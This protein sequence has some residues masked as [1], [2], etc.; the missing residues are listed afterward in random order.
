MKEQK[1]KFLFFLPFV[2]FIVTACLAQKNKS[3]TDSLEQIVSLTKNDSVKTDAFIELGK[4]LINDSLELAIK[5]LNNAKELSEKINY[6]KGLA[7]SYKQIGNVFY[8][9]GG[10]S[11]AI[12]NWSVALEIFNSINDVISVIKTEGNIGLVYFD[13]GAD[14]KALEYYFKGLKSAEELNDSTQLCVMNI[15][16][17]AV[18]FN[19]KA[20]QDKALTY[21]LKALSLSSVIKGESKNEKIGAICVNIGEVYLNRL[22]SLLNIESNRDS[23]LYY[24]NRAVEAYAGT[25]NV[26]YALNDLGKVYLKLGEYDKALKYQTEAYEIAKKYEAKNDLAISLLA[27]A[28]TYQAKGDI[29]MAL[30]NYR[31]G[32]QEAKATKAIY[33]LEQIYKGLTEVY[34]KLSDFGN[35]LKYQTLLINIK[36]EIYTFE[37]DNKIAGVE[38][39]VDIER[40][41]GQISLLAKDQELKQKEISR[42]K[43][44]RNGFMGGFAIVLLFAGVFFTQRNRI[45]KEKKRSDELLLNILPE[46]T[47]EELK[48]TGTA[49]AKSID[50]VTVMF[51]DF[52]NFTQASELLSPEQL[53]KEINI[54]YSEFDRIITKHGIEKIKTIGDAY[55]CAGGLPT[56]N[57]TNPID[58]IK[59]GLEM[60]E[61]IERNKKDR[62]AI[63]QPYFELRLGIHTGPVVAGIVGIKKF[64]YD[65]W[66]DTVNTASRMESSGQVGKVNISGSTYELVKDKF[67]CTHRGKIHAKNKGEI[68]MY[69]VEGIA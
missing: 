65:I 51:T 42:Q 39:K 14:E 35:A 4:I 28:Q 62:I 56:A 58:V 26:P 8:V 3:K 54:C 57:T 43:M 36:D 45:S 55:M 24:F 25:H 23:A 29:K 12:G 60:Q 53:V 40:K 13:Q 15:N 16:I 48:A 50:M 67:I 31:Q 63:D 46:E 47:A 41:K 2:F 30:T 19:K 9:K 32:E 6:K 49:K 34:T 61:F 18:F 69:F 37:Q 33:I 22:D 7:N 68:D 44:V 17:G 59:A 38:L 52:K 66:G 64:A 20:T 5:Y 27:L 10:Y 1:I 21:Y 11:E